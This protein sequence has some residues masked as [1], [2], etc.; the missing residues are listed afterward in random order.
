MKFKRD[1]GYTQQKRLKHERA[2]N[3]YTGNLQEKNT[4]T[5][6]ITNVIYYII[7]QEITNQFDFE[8]QLT[9]K[10]VTKR[11][12]SDILKSSQSWMCPWFQLSCFHFVPKEPLL[13][14]KFFFYHD[15]MHKFCLVFVSYYHYMSL[16]SE[17]NGNSNG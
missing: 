10:R 11:K 14:T 7:Y 6:F 12:K 2:I 15:F 8:S 5:N 4:T 9:T 17:M 16:A 1:H 3:K 13:R